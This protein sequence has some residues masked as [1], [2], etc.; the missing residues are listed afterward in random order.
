[1]WGGTLCGRSFYLGCVFATALT[2]AGEQTAAA[3]KLLEARIVIGHQIRLK[4]QFGVPDRATPADMWQRL[5]EL[6]FE[7]VGPLAASPQS[8]EVSLGVGSRLMIVWVD[9]TEAEAEVSRLRLV[10]VAGKDARWR[11]PEDEVVRTGQAAGFDIGGA[12]KWARWGWMG[13]VGLVA[14]AITAR[15]FMRLRSRGAKPTTGAPEVN[16]PAAQAG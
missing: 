6:E 12:P 11:I 16:P 15:L 13:G 10:R 5:G 3:A 4:S 8:P 7:E 2:V 14:L 9:K 1:M